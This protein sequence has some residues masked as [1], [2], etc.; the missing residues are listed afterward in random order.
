VKCTTDV[1]PVTKSVH[2]VYERWGKV[3]TIPSAHAHFKTGISELECVEE[4]VG[5]EEESAASLQGVDSRERQ[6]Y[7][8]VRESAWHT[9]VDRKC[10]SR[11]S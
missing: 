3:S 8:T 2:R 1:F 9:G 11:R 10:N 4:A 5:E 6:E 7:G